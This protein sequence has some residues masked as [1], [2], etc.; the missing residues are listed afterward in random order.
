MSLT[1]DPRASE[2]PEIDKTFPPRGAFRTPVQIE[3]ASVRGR[4]GSNAVVR[5]IAHQ[6]PCLH[7]MSPTLSRSGTLWFLALATQRQS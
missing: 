6:S 2:I 5:R 1:E 4:G 3:S 7:Q